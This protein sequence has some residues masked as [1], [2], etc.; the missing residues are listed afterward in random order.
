MAENG[1]KSTEIYRL[2]PVVRV[3]TQPG[4]LAA[5]QTSRA[6]L[7][8]TRLDEANTHGGKIQT[9]GVI[10]DDP[11][12]LTHD[13]RTGARHRHKAY[14]AGCG[15]TQATLTRFTPAKRC[16]NDLPLIIP[17]TST[18]LE[19]AERLAIEKVPRSDCTGWTQRRR[20][21]AA[22]LPRKVNV[23]PISV[24]SPVFISH[25]DRCFDA[26]L[27]RGARP[28]CSCWCDHKVGVMSM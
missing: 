15:K 9:V 7:R 26:G 8:E 28:N 25:P 24:H 1:R 5:V 10:E 22:D 4:P 17:G 3:F 11:D 6:R 18:R 14:S 20:H 27:H 23:I 19:T 13:R 12:V 2:P 16:R 21:H